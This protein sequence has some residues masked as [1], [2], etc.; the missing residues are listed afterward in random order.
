MNRIHFIKT[1]P[2]L[3]TDPYLSSVAA[4]KSRHLIIVGTSA[5]NRV[6]VSIS[7]FLNYGEQLAENNLRF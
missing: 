2:V 7:R 4:F 3:A 5:A 1:L 6:K